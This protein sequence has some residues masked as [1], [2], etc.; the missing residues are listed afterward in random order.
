MVD[1][2]FI[3]QKILAKDIT[4]M[5]IGIIPDGNRRYEKAKEL[6]PGMGHVKGM[7]NM[8]AIL[9]HIEKK[10]SEIHNIIVYALSME[11]VINRD[12]F[13]TQF[14][15]DMYEKELAKFENNEVD[16]RIIGNSQYYPESFRETA[17]NVP[18]R[19]R[20]TTLNLLIAY[21]EERLNEPID[22][23][24]RTGGQHRLSGFCPWDSRYAN[25]YF[26]DKLFPDFGI[27]DFEE[28]LEWNKKQKNNYG[29]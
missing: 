28:A 6:D 1:L 19:S 16:I 13:E 21:S 3:C 9:N 24:I 11:N 14:L 8:K 27:K 18:R 5:N 2:V 7:E 25:L 20:Q 12:S 4:N 26:S 29:E 22:L 23:V 10:H 17:I 15:F